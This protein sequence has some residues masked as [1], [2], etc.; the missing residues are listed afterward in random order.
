MT[1][2]A[3]LAASAYAVVVTALMSTWRSPQMRPVRVP[4]R[5]RS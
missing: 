3:W 2:F 1:P 4:T 5:R